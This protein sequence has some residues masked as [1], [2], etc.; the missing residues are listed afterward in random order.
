MS[1]LLYHGFLIYLGPYV[2]PRFLKTL[3]VETKSA[4]SLRNMQY[5]ERKNE[6]KTLCRFFWILHENGAQLI[7]F[8]I[9][10]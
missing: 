4:F 8:V 5:D 1:R 3:L 2:C 10:T 6:C 7:V 9:L